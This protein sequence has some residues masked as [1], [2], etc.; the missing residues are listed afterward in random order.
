M[1]SLHSALKA[2][3]R[4]RAMN[5]DVGMAAFADLIKLLHEWDYKSALE[6]GCVITQ[7]YWALGPE[8]AYHLG[9]LFHDH[10]DPCATT[11]LELQDSTMKRFLSTVERWEFELQRDLEAQE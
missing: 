2:V 6:Q 4:E 5:E 11:T 7:V 9:C 10:G 1:N 8:A 3:C